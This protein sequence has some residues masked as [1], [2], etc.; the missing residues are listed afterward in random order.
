[1]T[2]ID[3]QLGEQKAKDFGKVVRQIRESKPRGQTFKS[4]GARVKHMTQEQLSEN[5]SGVWAR[6]TGEERDFDD[7][8]IRKLED[9]D[10]RRVTPH[11]IAGIAEALGADDEERALLL[12]AAG[13]DEWFLV[14][15]LRQFGIEVAFAACNVSMYEVCTGITRGD[16][17]L[18]DA[19]AQMR[20]I[21]KS[22]VIE[23]ARRAK[24][25]EW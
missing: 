14:V 3:H 20:L 9:G 21:V 22:I 10:I 23:L 6:L 25:A 5:F 12:A 19:K 2:L 16:L 1:M 15:I 13:Y 11:F 4:G 24:E 18:E 7:S 17:P 8:W